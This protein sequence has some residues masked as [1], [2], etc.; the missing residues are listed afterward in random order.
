M[1]KRGGEGDDS[2]MKCIEMLAHASQCTQDDSCPEK[3]SCRRMSNVLSHARQCS[4][5]NSCPV[6]RQ[7]VALCVTHSRKCVVPANQKCTVPFC[8]ELRLDLDRRRQ[9]QRRH[10]QRMVD[11]RLA[12]MAASRS[13]DGGGETSEPAADRFKP[14]PAFADCGS[15]AADKRPQVRRREGSE[16]GDGSSS[17]V[18][19]QMTNTS[20][21]NTQRAW[22]Q[23]SDDDDN[24]CQSA[25]SSVNR[26]LSNGLQD[27]LINPES[28]ESPADTVTF[29]A[30]STP[31]SSPK[32]SA[33]CM[34]PEDVSQMHAS[35]VVLL[36]PAVDAIPC[37]SDDLFKA[38]SQSD[39]TVCKAEFSSTKFVSQQTE[40]CADL[41]QQSHRRSNRQ[42]TDIAN[43][44]PPKVNGSY[45]PQSLTSSLKSMPKSQSC[46][47]FFMGNGDT[48][49]I[50]IHSSN[51]SKTIVRF[52]SGDAVPVDS[53]EL[54]A[55]LA[56]K[57]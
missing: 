55:Q 21:L 2:L 50:Y 33:E 22:Q 57:L 24:V 10:Q 46:T 53:N 16:E 4:L 25:E 48:T 18:S 27:P 15:A 28:V 8:A 47:E 38:G 29:A 34:F 35:D 20:E 17:S 9:E 23:S 26:D 12:V 54:L 39:V 30:T 6:C 5:R 11:S 1:A 36:N 44:L 14:N 51:G 7:L 13:A 45:R 42:L 41:Q 31:L 52:N 43:H 49:H 40:G 19:G 56:D 37:T 32:Q 3:E